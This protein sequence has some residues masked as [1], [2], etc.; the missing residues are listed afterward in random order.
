MAAPKVI[1]RVTYTN[2]S[3]DAIDQVVSENGIG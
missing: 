2:I 1:R 3:Q